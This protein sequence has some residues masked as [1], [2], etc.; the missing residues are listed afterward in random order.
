MLESESEPAAAGP[1]GPPPESILPP[2]PLLWRLVLFAALGVIAGTAYFTAT[3]LASAGHAQ[4]SYRVQAGCGIVFFLGLAALCSKSLQSV[5]RQTLLWGLALQFILAV[6]VLHS[7]EVR[8]VLEWIGG[9][10]SP[11]YRV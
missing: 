3:A 5:R 11:H 4:I 10:Q 8:I 9:D 7:R 6:A 2:T 1:L